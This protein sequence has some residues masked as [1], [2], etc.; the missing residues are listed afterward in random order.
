MTLK[1]TFDVILVSIVLLGALFG[2]K[3]GF[4]LTVTKP[5]KW[6]LAFLLAFLLAST[7]SKYIVQPMI[8][9]P[10][11]NQITKYIVE[12]CDTITPENVEEELPT[13]LKLAAG[14]FDVDLAS[15]ADGGSEPFVYKL[16]S[17]LT[18]PAAHLVSLI[19][20]FF[21]T[22]ILAKILLSISISLLN[23]VFEVGV[24]DT[25]NKILGFIFGAGFAFVSAWLLVVIF[26]YGISIPAIAKTEFAAAFDGGLIYDFFK[27]MSPLD[28]LLS[29]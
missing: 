23:H 24:L 10:L 6:F 3:R 15:I 18:V 22:Y 19:L 8:E 25:F 1:V 13:L 27:K 4:I 26:D 5:V 2:F 14:A 21:I 11:T 9:E 17:E 16:V 28:L 20:S 12:E 29:F 7:V